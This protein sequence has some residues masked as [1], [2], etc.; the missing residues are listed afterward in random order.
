MGFKLP[1]V[2]VP[3]FQNVLDIVDPI[4]TLNIRDIGKQFNGIDDRDIGDKLRKTPIGALGAFTFGYEDGK[5]GQTGAFE[6]FDETLG[7]ITGRNLARQQAGLA[8][9]RLQQEDA[10]RA[11]DL[12]DEQERA[13]QLDIARSSGAQA[14]RN[15]AYARSRGGFSGGGFLGGGGNSDERDFLGL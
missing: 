10:R 9:T 1:S 6:L 7:E 4:G 14:I 11:Q 13:K 3:S 2:S 12:L 5:F 15:S 8:E